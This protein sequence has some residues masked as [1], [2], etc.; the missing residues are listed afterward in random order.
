MKN[1][2][3]S[4]ENRIGSFVMGTYVVGDLHGCFDEWIGFKDKIEEIDGNAKFILVGDIIDRGP[5]VEELLA[6]A[7]QNLASNGKYQMVLGNHEYEQLYWEK[8]EEIKAFYERLPYYIDT[9]VNNKRF[10]IVHADIP[11]SI[12]KA[13][14]SLKSKA[15]IKSSE[16]WYLVWARTINKFD[17]IPDAILVHGHNPT[18]FDSLFEG[19]DFVAGSHTAGRIC[20]LGNRYNIDGGLVYKDM[21]GHRLA[22]LRLDDLK[23]FYDD[24]L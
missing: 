7:M 2:M 4:I 12:I 3:L 23:E 20:N 6:W 16:L 18:V 1:S 19:N 11:K 17:S 13:D 14:F 24:E 10:I 8:D 5:K 9:V 15:E 21:P 22:A